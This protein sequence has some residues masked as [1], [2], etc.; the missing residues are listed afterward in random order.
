MSGKT[1]SK[2]AEAKPK[3]KDPLKVKATAKRKVKKEVLENGD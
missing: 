3:G 1:E 2:K